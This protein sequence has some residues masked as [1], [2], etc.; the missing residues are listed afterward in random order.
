[1]ANIYD[2][3]KQS[4]YSVATV[5]R[6]ING[7][8]H[9]SKKAQQ[10]VEET[11]ARLEFVPNAMARN[12]SFGNTYNIGVVLPHTKHPFF[13][14]ILNGIIER[15]ISTSYQIVILPS[16]YDEDLELKYLEQLRK[17]AID[18]II[19]TSH[20]ISLETLA[21][22]SEYGRIV[23]C[24]KTNRK[25]I[26]SVYPEREGAYVEAFSWLKE[27]GIKQMHILLSRSYDKSTTSQVTIDTFR[28]VYAETPH[29]EE[30]IT[31][32]ISNVDA[33]E[34]M[35]K[36]INAGEKFECI[37]S[38]GDDV[39]SGVYEA[40]LESE[41]EMPLI[42]GQEN[43]ISGGLLG[44]PTVEHRFKEIGLRAFDLAVMDQPSQPEPIIS[45][46]IPR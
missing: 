22:F 42:I 33:K 12:L 18:A 39:A 3:A 10:A 24:E 37:F 38:N 30:I 13:T 2:I 34:A 5:S 16:K 31:G 11:M 27:K 4:G 40:F 43:Q 14:E 25:E 45:T 32:I 7:H 20:G 36:R 6:V 28:K 46:F 23:C 35:L 1:M 21:E 8:K 15:A 26:L 44:L 19:F 17:K 29:K 9:V 41:Q